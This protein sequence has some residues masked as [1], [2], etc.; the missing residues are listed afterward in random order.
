M[1]LKM[2]VN[3]LRLEIEKR[4]RLRKEGKRAQALSSRELT[5]KYAGV[6]G[7]SCMAK[8]WKD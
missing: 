4:I 3:S 5:A 8:P 7:V 1:L 2:I 6:P